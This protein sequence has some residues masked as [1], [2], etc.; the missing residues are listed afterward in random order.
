[1][2][3]NYLRSLVPGEGLN[4]R[5]LSGPPVARGPAAMIRSEL[6]ARSASTGMARAIASGSTGTL[7]ADIG[8]AVVLLA[9]VYNRFNERFET[10]DL[11]TTRALLDRLH[12]SPA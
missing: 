7:R 5:R 2:S 11:K 8:G 6:A 9:W 12:T 4:S 10:S 3:L 1:M